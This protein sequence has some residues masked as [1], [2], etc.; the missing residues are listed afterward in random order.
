MNSKITTLKNGFEIIS[1]PKINS[2]LISLGILIN[3]IP[4]HYKNKTNKNNNE[5]GIAHFLEHMCFKGTKKY[6]YQNFIH[7]IEKNN[8]N[9]NAYTS[10]EHALFSIN[11]INNIKNIYKSIDLLKE[12]IFYPKIDEKEIENEKINIKAELMQF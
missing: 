12:I 7:I 3:E 10:K 9:I 11:C 1:L 8:F 5:T 6:P 2:N 4:K